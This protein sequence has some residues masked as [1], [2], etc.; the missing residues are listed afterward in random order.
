MKKL[1]I[2]FIALFYIFALS[3]QDSLKG[4]WLTGEENTKIETYQ[5]DGVW[6]GKIVS[7]DNP[8]AKIGTDILRDLKK[9]NGEW[10]GKIFAAKRGKIMDAIIEPTKNILKITVSAGFFSK[11]LE[12]KRFE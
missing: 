9:D 10:K 1:S 7:S 6:F 12:W 5:K 3:A 2:L 11:N 8:N 4:I